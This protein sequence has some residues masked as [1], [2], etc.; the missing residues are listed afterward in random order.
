MR[1]ATNTCQ[2]PNAGADSRKTALDDFHDAPT[3]RDAVDKLACGE[4][5]HENLI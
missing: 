3:V 5:W 4:A 1:N 2:P